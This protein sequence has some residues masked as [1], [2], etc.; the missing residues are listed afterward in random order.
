[1]DKIIH[2]LAKT[3]LTQ[4]AD[5]L[6]IKLKI[7][8]ANHVPHEPQY[9]TVSLLGICKTVT[10]KIGGC[11]IGQIDITNKKGQ[12]TFQASQNRNSTTY[13]GAQSDHWDDQYFVLYKFV[14]VKKKTKKKLEYLHIPIC[15][16]IISFIS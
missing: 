2:S 4:F 16:G 3:K 6:L 8:C 7:S 9:S 10:D 11:A 14:H 15:T 1:M 12:M 13:Y 5:H